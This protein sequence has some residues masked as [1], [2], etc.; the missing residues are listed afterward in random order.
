MLLEL[1][2][3][4]SSS[5]TATYLSSHKQTIQERQADMLGSK[6]ELKWRYS[7]DIPMLADQYWYVHVQTLDAVKRTYQVR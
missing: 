6:D 7:T 1:L 2:N 5:C 3:P 4:E